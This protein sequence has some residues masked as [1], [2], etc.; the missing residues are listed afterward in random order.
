MTTTRKPNLLWIFTDQLRAQALTS[1]GDPNIELP[2]IGRIAAEGIQFNHAFSQYPVCCPFRGGLIT[3]QHANVNGVRIQGDL[4]RPEKPTIAHAFQ[5]AGYRTSWVGKW[6]LA[7]LRGITD[8]YSG[9]DYWVHPDLRGGFEDW[10]GFEYSNNF[11]IT[12]YSHGDT[13]KPW[14]VEGYQTDGLTDISLQY[15]S[16]FVE[17][18]D[19][20]WFH[21]LSVEAPHPGAG[22][23]EVIDF[24]P[25]PPAS[26]MGNPA[27][28]E[29]EVRFDMEELEIRGN[30][31]EEVEAKARKRLAGYYAQVANID[32]NVGR[33]L[34]WLEESG[35]VE[36]TLVVFFSDHG[37]LAGSHGYFE[38]C[39]VFEEAINIPLLMRLPRIIPAG[40]TTDI[41][42]SGI[43]IFPTCAG[44]CGVPIPPEVQ[45]RNLSAAA[46]G[47]PGPTNPEVLIQFIG[48]GWAGHFDFPFRAIRTERYTFA[49]G[50]DDD[51]C[52]LFDNQED[53]LQLKNLFGYPEL[54]DLQNQ[55]YGQLNR[56]I[57]DSGENIPDFV[58][59]RG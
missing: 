52:Y 7:G 10:Y 58:L 16:D 22:K 56:A 13:Y 27:P 39:R 31:P 26:E 33:V 32:D 12:H 37:E 15:L 55:L 47:H 42:V 48:A 3:G 17:Q 53:P 50:R 38:K 18:S 36:N 2:N 57:I 25:G 49:L 24:W 20:P 45:G 6:H 23:D 28:P 43:D 35:Q 11:Y 5:D 46:L 9:G 1:Y 54:A 41:L 14:K 30:V 40:I 29:Y 19:Q 4:I 59:R 34:D 8:W 51:W 21:C 44:F